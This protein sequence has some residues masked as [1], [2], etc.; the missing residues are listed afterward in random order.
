MKK[1]SSNAILEEELK[2]FNWSNVDE[3]PTFETCDSNMT[4]TFKKECFVNEL[5]RLVSKNFKNENIVLNSD[6]NETVEIGLHISNT[7]ELTV[8]SVEIDSTASA[9]IPNL[10]DILKSSFDS[11]P[12]I[13]PA[14]KRGQQVNVEFK[15]P[16]I[17]ISD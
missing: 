12:K 13:L 4:S 10:Q 11:I 5:N 14:I 16:V 17:I 9:K 1:T 15:L 7:G 6:F 8:K 2:T 3:F